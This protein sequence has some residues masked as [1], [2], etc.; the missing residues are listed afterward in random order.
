MMCFGVVLGAFLGAL[1]RSWVAI[2]V[3]LDALVA[4][5]AFSWGPRARHLG[6]SWGALG[7][8][9]TLWVLLGALGALWGIAMG[10]LEDFWGPLGV[11]WEFGGGLVGVVGACRGLHGSKLC[12]S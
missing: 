2:G 8:L 4:L 1:G 11:S 3:L 10:L 5:W 9:G 7:A 6:H 12:A